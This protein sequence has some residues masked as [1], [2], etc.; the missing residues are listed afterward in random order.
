MNS[1]ENEK[2]CIIAPVIAS[3]PFMALD[4]ITNVKGKV[5]NEPAESC[6]S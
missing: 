3:P 6:D 4:A 5:V 2:A 1:F